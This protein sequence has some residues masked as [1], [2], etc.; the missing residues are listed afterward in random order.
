MKRSIDGLYFLAL[1]ASML[2]CV[3]PVSHAQTISGDIND[4]SQVLSIDTCHNTVLVTNSSIFNVGDR[5]LLIEMKGAKVDTTNTANFGKVLDYGNAAH[6]E[7]CNVS[8]VDGLTVALK[9]KL[10]QSYDAT[11]SIQLVRVAV[12]TNATIQDTVRPKAWSGTEGGIT[13]MEVAD[14]LTFDGGTIDATGRGFKGGDYSGRRATPGR[15]G[16]YYSEASYDGGKKGESIA[17]YIYGFEAGRGPLAHG[18]GGGND[19]NGGGGGG[20]N[21]GAGGQG[22]KQTSQVGI[23]DNGGLGAI[24]LDYVGHKGLLTLGGGG[25]GGHQNDGTGSNGAA[26]GG[27]VIIRAG[28]IVV[29]NKG[30]IQVDGDSALLA[31]VDGAGGGGGGGTVA[32]DAQKIVGNLTIYAR[33]GKGGD[34]DAFKLKDYC[35]APGGGG[36]GGRVITSA[37][38][39]LAATVTAGK[40]GVEVS[41]L[42]SCYGTSYGAT[43]GQPGISQT[44][45]V[46]AE[47][48]TL[49]TYPRAIS[50]YD[51]ICLGDT[52]VIGINGGQNFSWAPTYFLSN[53]TVQMPKARP[54]T[55]I[56]YIA[57]YQDMRG[58]TFTDTVDV[59]V[60]FRP[61]PVINGSFEVCGDDIEKYYLT[62]APNSTYQWSIIGGSV[63][64]GQGSDTVYVQWNDTTDGVIQIDATTIG[65]PCIGTTTEHVIIHW[66]KKPLVQGGGQLCQGDSMTLSVPNTFLAY[67]WNNGDTTATTKVFTTGKYNCMV[68]IPGGCAMSSDTVSVLV[69]PL[70][71]INITASPPNLPDSGGVDTL[72]VG[73]NLNSYLWNTGKIGDTL[74]VFDSGYFSVAV[75]D[76][77]GCSS[78]TT[79][80]IIRDLATP[81]VYVATDTITASPGDR[82]VFPLKIVS[83]RNLLPSGDTSWVATMSFNKTLLAPED[84]S[85]PSTITGDIRTL[86]LSGFRPQTLDVGTLLPIPCNVYWGDSAETVVSID[87][88]DFTSGK[89][90]V[91]L[92]YSGLLKVNVCTAGGQ[93][94]FSQSGNVGITQSRP[95]PTASYAQ[96]DVDLIE[97]GHTNLFLTDLVGRKIRDVMSGDY[98]HGHY[99]FDLDLRELP[100]GNYLY[101]LQT[102]SQLFSRIL[103]IER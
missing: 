7:F 18:G 57:T 36:G 10:M 79:I 48:K 34:N 46:L 8:G 23:L 71:N 74:T 28:A 102:P 41:S 40:S 6:Y 77:N 38:T 21:G 16:Y 14:T 29:K 96:I 39:P 80:H 64:A 83:S 70:P 4:F 51:T 90:A 69:N 67:K 54:D 3:T 88:F 63:T 81:L 24:P 66:A 5:V 76:S 30:T 52:I 97:D 37:A 58:C 32:I 55:S 91:I 22:G 27:L 25:G 13:V 89:K 50:R 100:R 15:L 87:A 42:V 72:V 103:T 1:V 62:N 20:G 19:Q 84:Q 47:S 12:Y 35:F 56:Q 60:N 43:D 33:G 45:L 65:A 98:K 68:T 86:T 78:T 85:I 9:N 73:G 82:V 94:L 61:T 75:V 2:L 53:P 95:N 31:G 44:G 92:R 26:G 49:F 59:K 11:G 99:S 93:R 101:V 17:A